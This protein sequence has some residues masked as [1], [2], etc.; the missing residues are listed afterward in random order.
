MTC[1]C[2]HEDTGGLKILQ[3]TITTTKYTFN[4]TRFLD[5]FVVLKLPLTC[6]L[7]SPEKT[8]A[9][10]PL[11]SVMILSQLINVPILLRLIF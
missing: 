11:R 6:R 7:R 2:L 9:G 1:N 4:L 5:F 3:I 8:V 10:L